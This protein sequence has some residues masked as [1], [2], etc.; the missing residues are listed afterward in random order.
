[1]KPIFFLTAAFAISSNM[2]FAAVTAESIAAD[3]KA[4]G[5]TRVEIQQSATRFKAEAFRGS[6]KLEAIYDANTGDV[7][8]T[9]I[10][11]NWSDDADDDHSDDDSDDDDSDDDDSDDDDSDDDDSDDDDSDDSDSDDSDDS[12]NGDHDGGDHDGGDHD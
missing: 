8:K 2:A 1:M 12:D 5:Y 3:L 4:Q 7:L 11:N 6:E 10:Y 9:E